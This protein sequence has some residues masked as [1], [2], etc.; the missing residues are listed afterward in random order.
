MATVW[1]SGDASMSLLV[2]ATPIGNLGDLSPRAADAL[3][4]ADAIACEDTRRVRRLL[5]HAGIPAPELIVV[6]DHTEAGS[7][8]RITE[9]LGAGATVVLTSDAGTPLVSDPGL[10]VVRAA[11]DAGVGVEV[12]PGPTAAI[13]GL[14]LSGF[15]TDR[16]CVEGFLPRKGA[17][18]TERLRQ[19]AG[20]ERTVVLYE[21]P[22]RLVRTIGDLL[23]V[24]GADRRVA[25]A[26]ELTKLHEEVWRGTLGAAK[27]LLEKEPPRGE[28]VVVLEGAPRREV[29]D[30]VVVDAV[31]ALIGE[32]MSRR[33]A[34]AAASEALGVA[35]NRVYRLA[36]GEG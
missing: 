29:S 36:L 15:A 3:G 35:S 19:V 17:A 4:R 6:N 21:A 14:V 26:R 7:I 2:V 12:I 27:H 10:L 23:S 1:S 25:L 11:I 33:D 30:D 34:V 32:G 9:L 13:A 24:C 8:R 20:E 31:T 18:R 28:Y 16:F 5:G 22:H